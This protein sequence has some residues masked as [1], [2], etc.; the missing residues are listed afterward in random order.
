MSVVCRGNRSWR[1]C[2]T[3]C[4]MPASPSLPV[5]G[6]VWVYFAAVKRL[7]QVVRDPSLCKPAA[8]VLQQHLQRRREL[9][10]YLTAGAAGG[11]AFVGPARDRDRREAPPSLRESLEERDPF[12]ADPQVRRAL[13]V[14]PRE[15]G[16]IVAQE[17]SPHS[18]LGRWR[19]RHL[20]G[21]TRPGQQ[22]CFVHRLYRRLM[23]SRNSRS[24]N[25][26][27]CMP[28][29]TTA[30]WVLPPSPGRPAM[31]VTRERPSTL[32]PKDR[33]TITSGTVDMHTTC[34][35]STR[36]ICASAGVS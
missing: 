35:P 31:F 1:G 30:S 15:H 16:A 33:A 19:H 29:A 11:T 5:E 23:M 26:A 18:E 28:I 3:P 14:A 8:P 22:L 34:A 10:E 13:D 7:G 24:I 32:S 21:S 2:G 36:N 12:R 4:R 9:P 27:C 25:G 6:L 20:H 17:R